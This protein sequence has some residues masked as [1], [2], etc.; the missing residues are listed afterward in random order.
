MLLEYWS[1]V[2]EAW[3]LVDIHNHALLES[4]GRPLSLADL[5]DAVAAGREIAIRRLSKMGAIDPFSWAPAGA[6]QFGLGSE[7]IIY[8]DAQAARFFGSADRHWAIFEDGLAW[9]PADP[10]QGPA[11]AERISAANPAWRALPEAEWRERFYGV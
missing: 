10:R 6:G 4:A 8:D 1:A 3:I 5:L 9:F 2:D 7:L 11:P